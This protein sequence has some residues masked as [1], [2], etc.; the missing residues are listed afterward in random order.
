MKRT[1]ALVLAGV[2][3]LVAAAAVP[4][5]GLAV[6]QWDT[7]F[8]YT[9]ETGDS[10]CA[11]VVHNRPE[12]AGTDDFRIDYENLSAT[13]KDHFE[14][15][16]TDGRYIVEDEAS[17]APD[18]AF[19]DDHVAAGEGCYAISYDR[20]TT[21]LRTSRESHRVGPTSQGWPGSLGQL[22]LA[23]GATSLIAGIGLRLHERME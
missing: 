3:F 15:A 21:A 12:V 13:G 16:L 9:V 18:F 6:I 1:T 2:V 4:V 22:L 19:T 14:R 8:V 23:L 17:T 5:I 20:E 10:Y 11:N 7:D